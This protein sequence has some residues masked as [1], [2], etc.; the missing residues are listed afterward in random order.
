MPLQRLST[1]IAFL[2]VSA[3]ANTAH[4]RWIILC[5]CVLYIYANPNRESWIKLEIASP[6]AIGQSIGGP[7]STNAL[8]FC[9]L[10]I[11]PYP[12]GLGINY[13]KTS[14]RIKPNFL[15][16]PCDRS[17]EYL[18]DDY[19][20]DDERQADNSGN[21]ER[22]PKNKPGNERNKH[23]TDSGPDGVCHP[24]RHRA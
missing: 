8:T 19:T 23:N 1:H 7:R 13:L 2:D 21:I 6:P 5:T 10:S 17:G 15:Q 4:S 12:D 14:W 18:Q 3:W 9:V 16:L 24:N 22:L 20:H 11:D